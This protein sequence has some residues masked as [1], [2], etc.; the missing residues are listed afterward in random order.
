MTI[1]ILLVCLAA[2]VFAG[3]KSGRP[4]KDSLNVQWISWP[5]LTVLAGAALAF[6]LVHLVNLMGFHTGA[7]LAQ[8]YQF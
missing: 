5:M 7:N 1:A 3:W 6:A 2:T 4:R 8:K